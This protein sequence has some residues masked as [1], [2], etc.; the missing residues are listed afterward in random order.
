[1]KINVNRTESMAPSD[2]S[3]ALW[4]R[5]LQICHKIRLHQSQVDALLRH[6]LWHGWVPGYQ[7][8]W[9]KTLTVLALGTSC[10]G[11]PLAMVSIAAGPPGT[12]DVRTC[13]STEHLCQHCPYEEYCS[14]AGITSYEIDKD[15]DG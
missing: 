3:Q 5:R 9:P 14:E 8:E 6:M 2:I 7:R 10:M 12:N 11:E 4:D 15:T 13:I 1:M